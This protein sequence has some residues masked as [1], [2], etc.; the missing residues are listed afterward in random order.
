MY[1]HHHCDIYQYSQNRKHI[2]REHSE[3]GAFHAVVALNAMHD[4]LVVM[5]PRQVAHVHRDVDNL[6]PPAQPV[7]PPIILGNL[8]VS[9]Q[10]CADR[11]ALVAAQQTEFLCRTTQF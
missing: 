6:S 11:I 4:Q 5:Y 2:S 7:A 1:L 8:A 3:S 9:I 10:A